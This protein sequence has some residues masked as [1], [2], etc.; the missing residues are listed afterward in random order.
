MFGN[1]APTRKYIVKPRNTLYKTLDVNLQSFAKNYGVI[2]RNNPSIYYNSETIDPD[3]RISYH[4]D[5]TGYDTDQTF[6]NATLAPQIADMSVTVAQ[7]TG[8]LPTLNLMEVGEAVKIVSHVDDHLKLAGMYVL[9]GSTINFTKAGKAWESSAM[10][11]MS[12][13]NIAMQ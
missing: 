7:I 9:K 2:E 5:M 10:I 3:K 1:L 6:I 4:K 11:Y 8:N 13:T 12:R